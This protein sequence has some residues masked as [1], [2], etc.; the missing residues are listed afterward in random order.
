MISPSVLDDIWVLDLVRGGASRLT[1]DSA[2]DFPVWSP[3]GSRIAFASNRDGNLNLY[4]KASNGTGNEELLLKSDEDKAPSDWSGDGRFLIYS[5]VNPKTAFDL[6]VLPLDGDRKPFAFLQT[7][8]NEGAGMLSPDGQWMAYQS[9]ESSRYEVYVRP[10]GRASGDRHQASAGK[11]SISTEGGVFTRWRGDGK[12][13]FYEMDRKIMAVEV[14]AG[15]S[16]G[17][18]TFEAGVP[19]LLFDARAY[20]LRSFAVTADGQRFL[21]NTQVS[22]EK[23]PS[24]TVILNW[25]AGLKP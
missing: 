18:R 7:Q 19:K 11:W 17:R 21:V 5:S 22:E 8:F 20:G 1:F 12:E 4:Q 24:V 16:K 25:A 3:D 6:W 15:V 9:T 10:F 2:A 23:S 14:K 13:L